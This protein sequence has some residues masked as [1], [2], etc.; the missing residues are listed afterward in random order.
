MSKKLVRQV[1]AVLALADADDGARSGQEN[2]REAGAEHLAREGVLVDAERDEVDAELAGQVADGGPD[3]SL[4]NVD[5][6]AGGNHGLNLFADDMD[7]FRPGSGRHH[8]KRRQPGAGAVLNSESEAE[9]AEGFGAE[10]SSEENVANVR[11]V[12]AGLVFGDADRQHRNGES[13]DEPLGDGTEEEPVNAASAV[14]CED[15]QIDAALAGDILYL[16]HH[17]AF[18]QQRG[19]GHTVAGCQL[20][21]LVQIGFEVGDQLGQGSGKDV[22]HAGAGGMGH[23]VNQTQ[24]GV[25]DSGHLDRT[26][27]G[28]LRRVSEIDREQDSVDVGNIDGKGNWVGCHALNLASIMN[29]WRDRQVT[30]VTVELTVCSGRREQLHPRRE[31]VGYCP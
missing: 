10:I 13:A 2:L 28:N 11:V 23:D 30:G 31:V 6:G 8:A 1:R 24:G 22:G 16:L 18:A 17:A 29:L 19:A 12:P 26:L 25:V 14:G 5:V 20:L 15:Q 3:L 9:A 7:G 21:H 4:G 27:E